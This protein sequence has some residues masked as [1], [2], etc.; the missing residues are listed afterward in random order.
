[1]KKIVFFLSTVFIAATSVIAQEV[2]TMIVPFPPGSTTDALAR[3][4]AKAM[5]DAGI[6][7]LVVNK[8]G[9]GGLIAL[10]SV[11]NVKDKNTTLVTTSSGAVV[12]SYIAPDGQQISFSKDLEPITLMIA[13]PMVIV[14]PANSPYK[15]LNDLTEDI[16]K[17][18]GK[19]V[20]GAHT[21]T[22]SLFVNSLLQKFDGKV[23]EVPYNGTGPNNNALLGNQVDFA[24]IS[25][26]DG[27]AL[28]EAGKFR[29]LG[30]A[31]RQRVSY[32]PDLP[33][34]LEQG[35]DL[36]ED[37]NAVVFIGVFAPAGMDPELKSRIN[38]IIVSA[39]RAERNTNIRF[40]DTNVFGSTQQ[41]F[42][43][44]MDRYK[45]SM[46]PKV[47]RYNKANIK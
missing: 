41:E 24:L 25:Y 1:M 38:K 22:S 11:T 40:K 45:K 27:K 36:T 19:V 31:T 10:R 8:P 26:S 32:S 7:T 3:F 6:P 15:N 20:Y 5:S 34:M 44:F 4:N 35:V 9:A 42:G 46:N 30:I 43:R 39:M 13:D 29:Y 47:E 28:Y 33:T 23:L 37:D 16:K 21:V 12:A 18:P 17:R 2:T 14:V